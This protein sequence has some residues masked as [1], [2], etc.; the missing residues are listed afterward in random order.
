MSGAPQGLTLLRDLLS[1]E[2]LVILNEAMCEHHR[3]HCPP[4][5]ELSRECDQVRPLYLTCIL[6]GSPCVVSAALVQVQRAAPGPNSAWSLVL[7]CF[8][9]C[10]CLQGRHLC[11][12][13]IE[14]RQAAMTN[15]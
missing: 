5:D 14:A 12:E 10:E 15:M 7:F 6:L 11:L 3:K 2:V 13:D 4:S 9:P 8:L 1:I